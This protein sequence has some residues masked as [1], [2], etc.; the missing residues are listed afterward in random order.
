M[1]ADFSDY[2]D[3]KIFDIAPGDIYLA[4]LDVANLTLPEFN[5]RVGTPED[6]IFQAMSYISALNIAAINRIPDRLMAAILLMMGVARQEGIPAEVELSI[7]A[8]SYEGA[9]VPAGTLFSY[10]TTFEDEVQDFVFQTVDTLSIAADLAEVGP[11]PSGTV[12]AQCTSP[13]LVPV[14][15]SGTELQLLSSGVPILSAEATTNFTN[16]VNADTDS[17]YLSRATTYLASLS[18]TLNKA[19]QVDAYVITNYTGIIGRVKTYDLTYGDP[20]LGDIGTYREDSPTGL[21]R[22]SN[23]VTLTFPSKHQFVQGEKVLI[24]NLASTYAAADTLYTITA[25]T[26]TTLSYAKSGASVAFFDISASA[27]SVTIG[28]DEPG[29]VTLFVYGL[30]EPVSTA[31]KAALQSDLV[32]KCSAGLTITVNDV[33][34]VTLEITGSVVLDAAFDQAPLQEA[35][36]SA[37]VEYL[38]PMVFPFTEG[39][40]RQTSLIS[41]ISRIPGV[42]Y[43]ESLTLTGTGTGWLPKIGNDLQFQNKGTLP[44]LAAEDIDITFTSL[45]L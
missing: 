35:V 17:D 40:I 27:G 37:L 41:L 9:T 2:I 21:S 32:N 10:Q 33:S 44:S 5:L 12:Y 19:S 43:V 20:A 29:Y 30:N 26:D 6:A 23:I 39:T 24:S 36:S 16:G 1:P 25:T 34:L 3:L 13:G 4:A 42:L 38:S 45:E 31:D 22:A 7:T 18:R 14:I 15:D 8:D 11:Y 28:E